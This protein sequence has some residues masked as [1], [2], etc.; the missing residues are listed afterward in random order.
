[1]NQGRVALTPA[2]L[3]RTTGIGLSL[4]TRLRPAGLED[5]ARHLPGHCANVLERPRLGRGD[6]QIGGLHEKRAD[7]SVATWVALSYSI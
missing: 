6:T 1:M 4:A 5:L 7:W 2:C 3:W